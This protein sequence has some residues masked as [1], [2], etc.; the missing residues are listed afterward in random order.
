MRI[1]EEMAKYGH[2]QV[3]FLQHRGTGLKGIVAIHDTTLGPALGGCR[4]RPYETEEEALFDVLRL[5]RGMTYK[6]GVVDVD[7]GGGKAVLIGDPNQDKSPELF[8]VFGRYVQGLGGRFYTGTDMGT[9]PQ[10]FVHAKRE[11]SCFVGLPVEYGGSGNTAVPTALGVFEAI[12]ATAM[13]LWGSTELTGRRFAVQGVGKV[14]AL[15]VQHLVEAGGAV[16]VTDVSQPNLDAVVTATPGEQ[17]L[18]V[19]GPEEIYGLDVDV[20]VPCALGAILND[21]TIYELRCAAVVGSANNQL[22]DMEKHGAMLAERGI[23]YA[24]D[25]LANAGGLIQV[26][27]ELQGYVPER[28]LAKT[29]AIYDMLL[30]VYAFSAEREIPTWLAADR[31][32]EQ[33]IE[34]VKDLKAVWVQKAR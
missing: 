2:E 34:Q 26:A 7:N 1:F 32:V 18:G 6:C 17:L 22:L 9:T 28:V 30:Q 15:V 12:K 10:D 20:F 16:Y 11:S 24:P 31:L 4:M 14:G 19:V 27:D 29:K 5:S 33:R 21:E 8:R 25:Y 13:W 3:H 23:L